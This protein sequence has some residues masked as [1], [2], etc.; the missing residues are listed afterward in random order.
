MPYKDIEKRREA[1]RKGSAKWREAHPDRLKAVRARHYAKHAEEQRARAREW[2]WA[3]WERAQQ[4]KRRRVLRS[5][6]GL[7]E[8]QYV[9]LGTA[10]QI[11]GATEDGRTNGKTKKP[12]RLAVDHVRGSKTVRGLLCG[13]CNCGIG[14]FKHDEALMLK[15]VEYLRLTS[16]RA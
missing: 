3:N 10:C 14:Y 12:F 8:E 6:Y 4:Q 9:A 5:R 2:Y 13:N 1:A 7:T 11:C 15:A 16:R